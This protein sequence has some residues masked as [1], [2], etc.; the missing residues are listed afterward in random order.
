VARQ[1]LHRREVDAVVGIGAYAEERARGAVSGPGNSGPGAPR[2]GRILHP[3]PASPM[4]NRGWGPQ[5]LRQL[6]SLGLA[7]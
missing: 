4:A 5:A 3:S 6:A 1:L 2:V 7:P